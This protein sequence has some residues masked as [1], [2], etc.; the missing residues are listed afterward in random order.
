MARIAYLILAHDRPKDL[1]EM[2]NVLTACGD[3]VV[4]HFD[5]NSSQ[6]AFQELVVAIG[7]TT[8]VRFAARR[9]CGWGDWSLVGA[10][11][12][13][14]RT[15]ESEFDDAT[16]FYLISGACAPIRPRRYVID[17]LDMDPRDHI[18]VEDL[19][20][21]DWIRTGMKEDRYRYRHF[22]NERKRP[23][24][25]YK[26][27]RFQRHFGLHREPPKGIEIKV[28]SQWWCLRRQTVERIL[29]FVRTRPDIPRFFR[30]V[31]IPDECFFQS[32][33]AH[34]VSQAEISGKPPT[35]LT[36]TDYGMPVTFFA[37]HLGFLKNQAEFFA[38]KI[39]SGDDLFRSQLYDLYSSKDEV[40][41]KPSDPRAFYRAVADAGRTGDRYAPRIWDRSMSISQDAR[42]YI[43][44]AKRW[45][46]GN[47]LRAVVSEAL[48]IPSYGYIFNDGSLSLDVVGGIGSSLD[49][50]NRHRRAFL[51]TL[52]RIEDTQ[53]MIICLDPE[54]T[55]ILADLAT[56]KGEVMV[57]YLDRNLD[58]DYFKG[59]AQRTGQLPEMVSDEEWTVL[60]RSMK[61]RL[62]R[63]AS[64]LKHPKLMRF[65]ALR[66]ADSDNTRA[67][68]FAS[69]FDCSKEVA[70]DILGRSGLYQGH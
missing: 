25:F 37:D 17:H 70:R 7:D 40:A 67:A 57:V 43:L 64:D 48:N 32:L 6:T 35:L 22:F 26:S 9:R 69:V 54:S 51:Q 18:E 2:V 12:D 38:R 33:V 27:L 19:A 15:A 30:S 3:Y 45:D 62:T 65:A 20:E 23:A 47:K 28:G 49:K 4:L 56:D 24:L 34:L 60:L 68:H 21:S 16:H 39:K 13:M 29:S 59:H 1:A 50:R 53:K 42:L 41:L 36:F 10:T 8:N 44:A 58:E 61:E 66:D 5:K 14:L 11:L 52:M 46:E 63:S 55:D 31:W